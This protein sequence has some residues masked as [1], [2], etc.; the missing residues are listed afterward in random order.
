LRFR[1]GDPAS[2]TALEILHGTFVFLGRFPRRERTEIAAFSGLGI[3]LARIEPVFSRRQFADHSA[4]SRRS[5]RPSGI[6]SMIL[7]VRACTIL[8]MVVSAVARWRQRLASAHVPEISGLRTFASLQKLADRIRKD[9]LHFSV[10]V[11]VRAARSS[12]SMLG[13]GPFASTCPLK[14]S[15][16]PS[17]LFR[18]ALSR[19]MSS[20]WPSA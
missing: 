17:N 5:R 9:G 1:L 10:L 16:H 8:V 4:A 7:P 11:V 3:L 13:I 6:S 19:A 12:C 20:T 2:P 14:R 18:P 15:T